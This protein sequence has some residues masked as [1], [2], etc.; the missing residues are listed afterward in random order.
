MPE[1]LIY[2]EKFKNSQRE[3]EIAE[4]RCNTQRF[5]YSLFYLFCK[6]GKIRVE[7]NK[8][9]VDDDM[10]NSICDSS[11]NFLSP[12]LTLNKYSI[13]FK[14]INSRIFININ[15]Q[16]IV[17]KSPITHSDGILGVVMSHLRV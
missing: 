4:A 15:T 10:I 8:T 6:K 5:P 17:T 13:M 16:K 3:G 1:K 9:T 7:F 2:V 12:T 14:N 11:L